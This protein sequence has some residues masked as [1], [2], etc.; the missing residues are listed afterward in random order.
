MDTHTVTGPISRLVAPL[1]RN[2]GAAGL[3]GG[4]VVAA[5]ICY[6]AN[7]FGWW[8]AT[9]LVGV[10]AGLRWRGRVLLAFCAVVPLLAW[11][12]DLLA[13]RVGTNL[14]EVAKVT[15]GLAGLGN[16]DAWLAYTATLLYAV[17]LAA[18][19][20][21]L[22]VSARGLVRVLRTPPAADAEIPSEM[23][24]RLEASSDV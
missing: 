14:T 13:Q 4:V 17:L 19:G 3:A 5:G 16:N 7:R 22:A 8:W 2:S 23:P 20:G 24:S 12:G 15:A 21:W 10:I 9:A 11:G 6:G 1:A 18:A